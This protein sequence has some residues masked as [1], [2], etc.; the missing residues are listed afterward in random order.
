MLVASLVTVSFAEDLNESKKVCHIEKSVDVINVAIV[1]NDLVYL[2]AH[3]FYDIGYKC[4]LADIAELPTYTALP[5]K[6]TSPT[7]DRRNWQNRQVGSCN[8]TNA[9]ISHKIIFRTRN[10]C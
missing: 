6:A 5:K 4:Y 7:Y 3:E 1:S 9:D 10:S 8:N 2:E